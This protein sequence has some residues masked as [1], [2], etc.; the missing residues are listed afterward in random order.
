MLTLARLRDQCVARPSLRLPTRDVLGVQNGPAYQH[1]LFKS[2][3]KYRYGCAGLTADLMG[4]RPFAFMGNKWPGIDML[5]KI[6]PCIFQVR[7]NY[8][9]FLPSTA[10]PGPRVYRAR[11]P[12]LSI[13]DR[14]LTVELKARPGRAH[15]H[16]L[17]LRESALIKATAWLERFDVS[18]EKISLEQF[19]PLAIR[20]AAQCY[21]WLLGGDIRAWATEAEWFAAALLRTQST[22]RAQTIPL[23]ARM[24][25]M[26]E[27]LHCDLNH[28]Y[29]LLGTAI[30]YGFVEIER[31]ARLHIHRPLHLV[32]DERES[33]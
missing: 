18:V 7:C 25:Q 30:A 23:D 5:L 26:A 9:V 2:P 27:K 13:V 1:D 28:A 15:L 20:N 8:P 17:F 21:Q 33:L 32:I 29:R 24:A 16:A 31:G 14:M 6:D 11:E 4:G 22:R 19:S 3:Q 12:I 10:T